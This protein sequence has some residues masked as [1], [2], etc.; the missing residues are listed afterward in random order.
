M[1]T[2]VSMGLFRGQCNQVLEL[3]RI[4]AE[5][6][7]MGECREQA[8]KA[9]RVEAKIASI[10][11][12][13]GV[14]CNADSSPSSPN[15][16]PA[17]MCLTRAPTCEVSGGPTKEKG[18]MVGQ[19]ITA[20]G[21]AT[22]LEEMRTAIRELDSVNREAHR[23]L[24]NSLDV[25]VDELQ[26]VRAEAQIAAVEVARLFGAVEMQDLRLRDFSTELRAARERSA[27][28][29][30]ASER[31][32]A[33]VEAC[34][35]RASTS[36]AEL[37]E[38]VGDLGA[39]VFAIR[40][41]VS[42][43]EKSEQEKR[44]VISRDVGNAVTELSKTVSQR[45]ADFQRDVDFWQ[46]RMLDEHRQLNRRTS[47]CE[48]VCGTVDAEVKMLRDV[49]SP[50]HPV[51]S[52]SPRSTSPSSSTSPL[53]AGRGAAAAAACGIASVTGTTSH[54]WRAAVEEA[55]RRAQADCDEAARLQLE[56]QRQADVKLAGRLS[57]HGAITTETKRVAELALSRADAAEAAARAASQIAK[58]AEE[59]VHRVAQRLAG[60]LRDELRAELPATAGEW[61]KNASVGQEMDGS[62]ATDELACA[63]AP[64]PPPALASGYRPS[65]PRNFAKVRPRSAA[66]S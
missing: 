34:K 27:A 15:S 48:A 30:E 21:I 32:G 1:E 3:A 19:C 54:A 6:A 29:L 63:S 37:R 46:G 52:R 64:P 12:A 43:F 5:L 53:A 11:A 23:K 40:E 58:T 44:E 10:A 35:T 59:G 33:D 14:R 28:S 38:A 42:A 24:G 22:Q 66:I 18:H 7:T 55:L 56:R 17:T 36:L 41:S 31:A 45:T 8:S 2:F 50:H 9:R 51:I 60:E 39:E 47:E 25:Q 4:F 13:E 57:E 20:R 49:L 16:L 62:W 26:T 65:P 61:V